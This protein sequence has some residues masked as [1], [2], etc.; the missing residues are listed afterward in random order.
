MKKKSKDLIST[1]KWMNITNCQVL[2]QEELRTIAGGQGNYYGRVNTI[3]FGQQLD[4][5]GGGIKDKTIKPP[6]LSK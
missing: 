4:V 2:S 3:F 6:D 1:D 5:T